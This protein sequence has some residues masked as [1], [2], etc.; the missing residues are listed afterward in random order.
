MCATCTPSFPLLIYFW[1][2]V[3]VPGLVYFSPCQCRG[4]RPKL[5][6]RPIEIY[7]SMM[8]NQTKRLIN[9][10][11][12]LI[13]FILFV[14]LFQNT[15][16]RHVSC[17]TPRPPHS[18]VNSFLIFFQYQATLYSLFIQTLYS[19]SFFYLFLA[20]FLFF[21]MSFLY[22]PSAYIFFLLS[23]F[24][25]FLA[26]SASSLLSLFLSFSG[27]IFSLCIN[28]VSLYSYFHFPSFSYSFLSLFLLPLSCSFF[29]VTPIYLNCFKHFSFS[30]IFSP[31][32]CFT[33]LLFLVLGSIY[34]KFP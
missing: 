32:P 24:L 18:F 2:I 28:S 6:P 8:N 30:C 3:N 33:F 25:C 31:C 17:S 11:E 13:I 9:Y 19:L 22:L 7:V 34:H 23:I 21:P 26:V 29:L 5:R 16:L 1:K 27:F 15:A 14:K 4:T 12:I 10:R 20:L